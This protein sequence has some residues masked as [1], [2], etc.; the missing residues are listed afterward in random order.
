MRLKLSHAIIVILIAFGGLFYLKYEVEQKEEALQ[1][2]KTQYLADQKALRVL[3]AEWAYLN[4]PDY[5]Q[6]MT[7]KYL[8]LKPVGSKQVVA[9]FNDVPE[10]PFEMPAVAIALQQKEAEGVLQRRASS[11]GEDEDP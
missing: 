9:W 2:L 6:T 4:S 10:R 11:P 3:K 8:M 1:A 5:L 7:E